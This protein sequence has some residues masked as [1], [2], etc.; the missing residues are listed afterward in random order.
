MS[1]PETAAPWPLDDGEALVP[2][3]VQDAETLQILMLGYVN[4]AAYER[5]LELGRM[6]FFSRSR[7]RLWT[8]GETS[9]N[10]LEVARLAQRAR[11]EQVRDEGAW[12]DLARE[13]EGL[14]RRLGLAGESLE[15]AEVEQEAE[16]AVAEVDRRAIALDRAVG[17]VGGHQERAEAVAR[18][19][20]RRVSRDSSE[21]PSSL[22]R[23]DRAE[24][25][26]EGLAGARHHRLGGHLGGSR[27]RHPSWQR[28]RQRVDVD[29]ARP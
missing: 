14:D 22:P 26:A 3:I 11:E 18:R 5:T 6:T 12:V 24:T 17:V 29:R 4:R 8:K 7:G 20:E 23:A 1:A 27:E 28:R 2:A 25:F 16:V 9:G 19:R 13:P 15:Y 10:T 21:G